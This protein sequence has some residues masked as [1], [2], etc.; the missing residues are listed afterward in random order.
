[1]ALACTASRAR[2]QVVRKGGLQVQS[3]EDDPP[4]EEDPPDHVACSCHGGQ[5]ER[6]R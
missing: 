1:M 5:P 4:D 3:E 6:D 2:R